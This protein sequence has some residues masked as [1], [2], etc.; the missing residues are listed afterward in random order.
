VR[1]VASAIIIKPRWRSGSHHPRL[2]AILTVLMVM[3]MVLVLAAQQTPLETT[4]SRAPLLLPLGVHSYS[5]DRGGGSGYVVSMGG[6]RNHCLPG[7][8]EVSAMVSLNVRKMRPTEGR[9]RS[10]SKKPRHELLRITVTAGF[11][12]WETGRAFQGF[13]VA[14]WPMRDQTR[15]NHLLLQRRGTTYVR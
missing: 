8:Q 12:W 15:Q 6:A 4:P 2:R 7:V 10:S 14:P 9:K 1:V 13:L 5:K 3:Q 11:C